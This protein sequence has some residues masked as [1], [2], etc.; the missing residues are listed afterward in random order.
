[1]AMRWGDLAVVTVYVSPNIDRADYASFLDEVVQSVCAPVCPWSSRISTPTR[2]RGFLERPTRRGVPC[3]DGQLDL[4]LLN[5]ESAN[6]C[7]AW[8]GESIVDLTWASPAA[9]GRVSGWEVSR[10]E[11]LSDHLYILMDVAVCSVGDGRP[12]GT[13]DVSHWSGTRTG[14]PR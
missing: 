11:T 4:R 13:R 10:E 5:Q 6:T 9:V 7:V 2:R 3:W 8:R 14:F 1:V 12:F